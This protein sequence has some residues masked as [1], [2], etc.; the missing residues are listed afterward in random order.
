MEFSPLDITAFVP[1]GFALLAPGYLWLASE[2]VVL[3]SPSLTTSDK[4]FRYALYSLLFYAAWLGTAGIEHI[5][6]EGTVSASA[7]QYQLFRQG[8]MWLPLA[9]VGG[10]ATGLIQRF[11][12]LGLLLSWAGVSTNDPLRS[13]WE[14]A[15]LRNRGC[16]IRLTFNTGEER[17][18]IYGVK[19]HVPCDPAC[20]DIYFEESY[21]KDAS[22][23]L[24]KERGNSGIWLDCTGVK[25]VRFY[26]IP[27][28]EENYEQ[29]AKFV[30]EQSGQ[31]PEERRIQGAVEAKP[32]LGPE[33]WA[34]AR[35]QAGQASSKAVRA[36]E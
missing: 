25:I 20:R 15:F 30:V 22:G 5:A 29:A 28:L 11:S 35:G 14:K 1:L 26:E 4:V 6:G 8:V 19:S 33:S 18:V 23:R 27:E 32:A 34:N 7:Y 21:C 10:V 36:A 17:F 2:R 3:P 16:L 13:A 12:L 9:I 24:V 31:G